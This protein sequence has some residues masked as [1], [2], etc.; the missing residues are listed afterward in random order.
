MTAITPILTPEENEALAAPFVQELIKQIRAQDSYGAWEKKP[1]ADLLEAFILDKEKR[2]LIPIMGD[3][4]P[5]TLWRL[6]LY[7]NAIGLTIERRSGVMASPMSKFSHEGFGRML[8]TAGRLVL[9]DKT[10]RDVHRFGFPSIAKLN[11]EGEKAVAAAL[12]WIE[13]FPD[14]VKA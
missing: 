7:Y 14:V 4:D 3:P 1:D 11:E 5:D 6:G 10:L 13:K 2:K 12:A 9:I 8:V